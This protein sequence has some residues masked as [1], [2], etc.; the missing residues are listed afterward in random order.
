[1]RRHTEERLLT[2]GDRGAA[3]AEFVLVVGFLLL[4]L[5]LGIVQ[6]GLFLHMR[7]VV[8]SSAAEA[9]REAANADR[10]PID[11]EQRARTLIADSLSPEIAADLTVEAAETFDPAGVR[12][13]A[14]R[15][16]GPLP[17]FFLPIGSLSVDVSAHAIEEGQ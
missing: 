1:M 7:N 12:L 6:L 3:V 4:P 9:A 17:L 16:R 10:G 5:F 13:S 2:R 8:T 15:V 14:V 11:G